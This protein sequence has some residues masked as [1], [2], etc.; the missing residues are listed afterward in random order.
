MTRIYQIETKQLSEEELKKYITDREWTPVP[1]NGIVSITLPRECQPMTDNTDEQS[2]PLP[3]EH[4]DPSKW[5]SRDDVE[6][7]HMLSEKDRTENYEMIGRA[8]RLQAVNDAME[9]ARKY[10][11]VA[12]YGAAA[13]IARF[14]VG[15]L[16]ALKAPL[17][18]VNKQ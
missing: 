6:R 1:E 4:Q 7:A 9:I 17:L 10:D 11:N 13:M 8:A 15:D 2:D 16:Q 18:G 5:P 12:A 3:R 14:I